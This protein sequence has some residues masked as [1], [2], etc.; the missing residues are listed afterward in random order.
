MERV[1]IKKRLFK[2]KRDVPWD[3]VE[4]YL[5]RYIGRSFA[6]ETTGDVIYI[7]KD[8]PDEYSGSRYTKN[9]RGAAAKAKA[10]LIP[11]IEQII[12]NATN[13]RYVDNKDPKHER[14]AS[15]GWYRFDILFGIIVQGENEYYPRE[16]IY[17]GTLVVRRNDQRNELYDIVNIKKE[18][19]KP[20]EP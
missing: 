9:L 5:K 4:E 17:K 15:N 18:A 19:S 3:D 6:V 8:L 14:D 1:T 11:E 16:N 7:P 10:N 2:G 13:R 12:K 20:L